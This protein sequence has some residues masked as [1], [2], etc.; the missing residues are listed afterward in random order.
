MS[1][2]DTRRLSDHAKRPWI[3]RSGAVQISHDAR[4][5][6]RNQRGDAIAAAC[7]LPSVMN[8]A[9]AAF[10]A[11]FLA[12]FERY[13]LADLVVTPHGLRKTLMPA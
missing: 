4:R 10:L 12:V 11:A 6:R 13:S 3:T 8:E 1:S 7:A 9:L 2:K 5:Y